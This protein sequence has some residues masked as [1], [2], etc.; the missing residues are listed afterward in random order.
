MSAVSS[1]L[2]IAGGL[3]LVLMMLHISA[4]V[5]LKY[6]LNYPLTGT[7]EIV[8]YYYMVAAVFLPLAAVERYRGHIFV[9]VFTTNLSPRAQALIDAVA[10]SLGVIYAAVLTW[11]TGIEAV[12]QTAVLEVWDATF[13]DI[14]V[15][16]T[17]WFLPLGCGALAVY[18]LLHAVDDLSYALKGVRLF[19]PPVAGPHGPLLHE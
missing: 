9:E 14:H 8:S 18:M 1:F 3:S 13:F 4:D 16:P 11:H 17:R 15:W 6:V 2:M 12:R 19:G 10:V 7:I 5:V